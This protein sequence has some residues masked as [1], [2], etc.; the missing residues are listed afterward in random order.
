[1][2]EPGRS[3]ADA[4]TALET[5]PAEVR[6]APGGDGASVGRSLSWLAAAS[7]VQQGSAFVLAIVLRAILGPTRTGVW[8]L[9]DVWRQQLSSLS[10]GVQQAADRDMPVLRAQ[11]R[12]GE[13]AEVRSITFTF[14]LGEVAAL[15][16][17]F[18]AY[19]VLGR[20][21]FEADVAFGF[22]LVP[23][24]AGITSIVS[25]YQL[26]LKNQKQFR[27]FS[28]LSVAQ[29]AIDWSV[30]GWVLIGGLRA[31]LVGLAVGWLARLGLYWVVVRRLGLF[32]LRLTLR[33][34]TLRRML[35]LGIPLSVWSLGYQ[36]ILR[37]DSL[38]VGTA[39]GTRQLGFYYL[40]PQV[41]AAL[42]T[43]PTALSVISYPNLM[44]TYGRTGRTGLLDHMAQYLRFVAL[45]VS[46]L[47]A[48]VGFFGM[49]VLVNGFLPAFAPGLRAMQ[50]FTLTLVF[51]QPGY[52]LVQVL[53]A[54][55][56][57][58]LLIGLTLAAV[59]VQAGVLSAG[60][61][62]GLTIEWAAASA[63][64]AQAV[65]TLALLAASCRLL[66][67][68]LREALGFW[69]RIPLIWVAQFA[70]V[71]AIDAAAPAPAGLGGSLVVA[72]GSLAAFAVG[73]ALAVQLGD[74]RAF[75]DSLALLRASG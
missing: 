23:I 15:A 29:L 54:E 25:L 31:L 75:R 71:Y 64:A 51:V 28:I 18:W 65:M 74:R 13:E 66:G 6:A 32:S 61:V 37:L 11:G 60:A 39:L 73:A 22:A 52:I 69:A 57:V 63:V 16:L 14:T 58:G 4:D 62:A 43:L 12:L 44:E 35:R 42:A 45:L 20:G 10:L 56:R 7:I 34:E 21:S 26:F 27:L 30:I 67:V 72:A 49:P 50:L 17:G 24:M 33:S 40:G 46:P 36:L 70:L 41:A 53:V 3:G 1:M 55:R 68:G 2:S 19:T 48:A 38:V 9:V 8:N 5:P 59:A 47:V